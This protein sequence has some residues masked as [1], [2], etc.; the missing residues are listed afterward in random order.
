[1]RN[2]R[3]LALFFAACI[4]SA[5]TPDTSYSKV[6]IAAEEVTFTFTYDL[7]TVGRMTPLDRNGDQQLTR[8]ELEAA[9]PAIGAY[10]RQNIF[11]ELNEREAAFGALAPPTWAAADHE[12]IRAAEFSQRLVTFTFRNPVLHA[13]DSVALTFGFFERLGERHTVLGSFVWN[14]QENP[15]IFTRFE[16]DYLFDTGYRVPAFEQFQSYLWL[17]VTH[18]FLGYDHVAFL[19]AL[20]FVRRFREL[21][22]IVTAF[23]VAHT[24]T[25]ALAA[26][27][28][29]SLPSRVVEAAIAASI[30]Y[31]A[32]ENL[33]RDPDTGHRWRLTFAFGLVHGFGFATVLRELGLPSEGLVRCL[34]SFNLGVE[35]GQLAIAAICWPILMRI[36]R[37]PWAGRF[38]I[39]MSIALLALGTVWLIERAFA[40]RLF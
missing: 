19:L 6:K 40:V 9:T 14:G 30:V 18:I 1:M 39:A 10:L 13:P 33:W 26:L 36:G 27:G 4:A 23:T 32:A 25:L 34:L 20:F 22:K 5:H 8:D 12:A 7:A 3:L 21:V 15:V 38:R 16:P 11:V 29:V 31:V 37:F 2:L 24:L 28:V 17:G 35:L